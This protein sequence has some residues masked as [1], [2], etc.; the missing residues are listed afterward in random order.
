MNTM[1]K[2][3]QTVKE[4]LPAPGTELVY[5]TFLAPDLLWTGEA[6]GVHFAAVAEDRSGGYFL[7]V[8]AEGAVYIGDL[9]DNSLLDYC[10][11]G[12]PQFMKIMKL[13][14]AA[15]E[16]TPSPDIDD[17]EGFRRCEEAER[18]LRQQIMEIDSTA[19]ADENGFWSA[20]A[21]EL[22]AGM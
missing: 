3:L 9:G 11:A 16:T 13:F 7:A 22:G 6:K 19:I 8:T 21:E 2:T 15:L 18:I 17:E 10:A 20:L 12:F 14:L 4:Y 5:Y 1:E